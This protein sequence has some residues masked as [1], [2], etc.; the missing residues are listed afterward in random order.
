MKIMHI[1]DTSIYNYDGISTYINELLEV[2]TQNGDESVVLTTAPFGKDIRTYGKEK[3]ITLK[4]FK[5]FRFPGKPKFIIVFPWG[6]KKM[7]ADFNP[8]II[9]IHTIGTIATKAARLAAGKHKVIYTKHC[10]DGELWN[11]YLNIPKLFQW[12]FNWTSKSLENIILSRADHVI[13]HLNDIE[14]VKTNK[15]F[16][17]FRKVAPPL[18]KRFFENRTVRTAVPS[19]FN[20]GFCGRA[21]PDKGIEKTFEGLNILKEKYN[22]ND[23]KFTFIGDGPEAHRM[24]IK[25][26]DMDIQITAYVDDVIPYIDMLD[27]FILSSL[28]ETISLSSLEAY[29][30]DVPIFSV[31]IGYLYEHKDKLKNYYLFE[32][33]ED[34]AISLFNFVNLE[35]V[36]PNSI[37]NNKINNLLIDYNRLYAFATTLC[38]QTEEYQIMQKS[39]QPVSIKVYNH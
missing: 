28:Q 6:M 27:G 33:P 15:F 24:R 10:F 12:F 39:K 4:T 37:L 13:Y 31:A 14:K 30:R 5:S 38:F 29:V 19:K 17:K 18:N 8:D 25:Y 11:A 9:W 26:P 21:E 32:T 16:Y 23:F 35:K 20:F 7:I 3:N 34:L 36:Q 1:T 22:F 2:A